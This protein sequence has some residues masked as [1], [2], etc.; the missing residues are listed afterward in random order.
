M[1]HIFAFVIAACMSFSAYAAEIT[2]SFAT[3]IPSGWTASVTPN[4][5]ETTDPARGAQF[6]KNAT[7]TLTGLTDVTS[8]K[9]TYSCNTAGKN[10]L[11]VAVGTSN[12]GTETLQK[13]TD[14]E[15]NFSG[16]AASGDLVISITRTEKSVY[17]KQVVITTNGDAPIVPPTPQDT[18]TIPGLNPDYTYADPTVIS[19]QGEASSNQPYTFIHNNVQ[20]NCTA[21]AIVTEADQ[22][23]FG[24]NAGNSITFT[25]TQ[26]MK[27]ISVNGYVK[28]YFD[29]TA[30]A[31]SISMVDAEEEGGVT[32]DPVLVVKDINSTTLTL[33]CVKQLRCY[34]VKITF[35]ANTTDSIGEGGDDLEYN[36]DF[37]P[38][39]ATTL[40]LVFDEIETLDMSEQL[41]Y[42]CSYIGLFNETHE[43]E[44]DIFAALEADGLPAAGTYPI[45]DTYAE[46]TVMAS[47]GGDDYMDYPSCIYT[48]YEMVD[49]D[50]YYN[51]AYYL[52][53][54]SLEIAAVAEGKE[55][56]LNATTAHGSTVTSTFLASGTGSGCE[57]LSTSTFS[58]KTM[59]NGEL[60]IRRGEHMFNVLGTMI[61]Q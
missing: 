2:Y 15:K 57:Q 3:S 52:V 26:P 58:T 39:E 47:P 55:L 32:V 59:Q 46:G 11:G 1:K 45:N 37:E 16:T 53:S 54:G 34:S 29:A 4:S 38:E 6:T 35:A 40:N 44:L 61:N 49:G 28:Q 33:N 18:T 56:R 42:I 48:D 5:F 23:Y 24:C 21:G 51:T 7:L 43:L 12:W 50:L 20:V 9:I 36:Y 25:T 30:S 10:T 31:G 22:P 19:V 13:V 27:S 8:V 17:I 41:G 60:I 14:V